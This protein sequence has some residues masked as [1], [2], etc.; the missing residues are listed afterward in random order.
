[1]FMGIPAA[2]VVPFT[3]IAPGLPA[4][5]IDPLFRPS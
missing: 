3:P 4:G 1:M 2:P 5:R